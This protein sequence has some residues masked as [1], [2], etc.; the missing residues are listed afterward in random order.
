MKFSALLLIAVKCLGLASA[1]AIANAD[2]N[3][4]V[5]EE[6]ACFES[7]VTWGNTRDNAL[8]EAQKHCNGIFLGKYNKYETR[9]KCQNLPGAKHVKFV[10]G[11][12]GNN[13][14]ATRN[15]GYSECVDGLSS[16]I[17]QCSQG[18]DTTYGRWRFRAD[19]N[20]GDC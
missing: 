10:V 2:D 5:L 19:P 20:A 15:L 18:G 1:L 6:R 9:T 3:V 7:G 17:I 8:V 16:E 12:T 13:A 14:P 4:N 11:L